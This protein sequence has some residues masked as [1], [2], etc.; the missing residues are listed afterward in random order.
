MISGRVRSGE[1]GSPHYRSSCKRLCFGKS[2]S[3]VVVNK[4]TLKRRR[5]LSSSKV[6]VNFD[7]EVGLRM[8]MAFTHFII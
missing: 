7:M 8:Y 1:T 6:F 4:M 5:L 2:F 3:L